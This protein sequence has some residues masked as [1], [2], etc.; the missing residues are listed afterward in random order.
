MDRLCYETL[1]KQGYGG[2]LLKTAPERVLQFGEGNF[3]RAFV[4]HFIDIMNERTGFNGKV[5]AVTPRGTG[6]HWNVLNTQEGLYTL[7]L[8][9][10]EKGRRVDDKRILSC[11]SR[12]INPYED[13]NEFLRCAANPDLRFIVSNTTEAGIVYD[14]L[15]KVTDEPA[16]SFPGK[17]TR[18]LYERFK[19]GLSGFII[20]SCELIDRNGDELLNCVEKYARLWE[21]PEEFSEWIRKENTFC[22]T[23]V[24]RIV[25][26]FPKEEAEK[27]WEELGYRD[28]LL[29]AGEIFASWVIEGPKTILDEFPADKAGLP[30]T[31]TDNVDPY[32]KRKVRILNGAHT[33]MVLAAFLAGRDIVRECMEDDCI[34][35]YMKTALYEEI[36]PVLKGLDQKELKEFGEAVF[37]R[38]ANP[39]IDHELLSIALNSTAKWKARVMPSLLEYYEQKGYLPKILTFSYAAYLSFYHCGRVLEAGVLKGERNGREFLIKDDE[40][41]LKEFLRLRDAGALEL[42]GAITDNEKMWGD[43]L[44]KL[45]GFKET[46][47]DDLKLITDMG[48]YEA[49]RK[50]LE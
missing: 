23:L 27:I 50:I 8:R 5:V 15:C 6:K 30:I 38:F 39:F 33:S 43:S 4:D 44:G 12:C 21:L 41:V 25:P 2:Y 14:P 29:D 1:E 42:V 40:W 47:T 16:S 9:G 7:L 18:F 36:I 32:K 10:R 19:N 37:D 17:L 13:H 45:P 3:L 20:L 46:V 34:R 11:I 24:D 35:G 48:M 26:G 28:D 22:S 49:M 31:I